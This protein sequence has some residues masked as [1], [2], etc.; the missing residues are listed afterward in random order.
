[1][2]AELAALVCL[3]GARDQVVSAFYPASAVETPEAF[4]V[5]DAAVWVTIVCVVFSTL[6][7]VSARLI[8]NEALNA[9][10]CCRHTL[11]A[12]LNF[13]VW[14]YLWH[15]VRVWHIWIWFTMLPVMVEF[16]LVLRSYRRGTFIF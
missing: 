7:F 11:S 4:R 6:V 8:Q 13:M 16:W 12:I 15:P 14:Y 5:Y 2:A 10:Q 3:A 1:M 9:V